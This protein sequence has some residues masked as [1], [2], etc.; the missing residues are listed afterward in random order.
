M[1]SNVTF[2]CCRSGFDCLGSFNEN[3]VLL[4]DVQHQVL[5]RGN[6]LARNGGGVQH[7]RQSAL[8]I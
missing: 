6:G 8:D 7:M 3:A 5:L 4:Q 1:A 2:N